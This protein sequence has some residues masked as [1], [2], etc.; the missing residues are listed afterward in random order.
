MIYSIIILVIRFFLAILLFRKGQEALSSRSRNVTNSV[1]LANSISLL[2]GFFVYPFTTILLVM[3]GARIWQKR[4]KR[5]RLGNDVLLFILA[6][7][8]FFN[9]PGQFSLDRL[10]GNI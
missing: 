1:E 9:G 3:L 10:L 4:K 8:I 6:L 2:F 5:Q 7:I